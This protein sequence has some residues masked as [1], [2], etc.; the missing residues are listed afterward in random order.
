MSTSNVTDSST[1]CQSIKESKPNLADALLIVS[2]V[3]L[4]II[5]ILASTGVFNFIG[6]TNAAYFS[7]ALYGASALCLIAEV[8]LIAIRCSGKETD[9][10]ESFLKKN[11]NEQIRSI[12]FC[13]SWLEKANEET[14]N[15]NEKSCTIIFSNNVK[16]SARVN[17]LEA[18]ALISSIDPNKSF[19]SNS[20]THPKIAVQNYRNDPAA[21]QKVLTDTFKQHKELFI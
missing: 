7:Y 15:N 16:I 3:A 5:G 13:D 19:C 20:A 8:I 9:V 1:C 2:G 21:A 4:L 17:G 18:Q 11:I 14:C 10:N 6:T 12:E